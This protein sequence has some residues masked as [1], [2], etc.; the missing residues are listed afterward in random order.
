MEKHNV[1]FLIADESK[2]EQLLRNIDHLNKNKELIDKIAVVA[3]NTS[4]LSCLS[5]TM[6]NEF[7][8]KVKILSEQN[9]DFYLCDNT[10]KRYGI[11]SSNILP[12]FTIATEGGLAK[13]LLLEDV[14]YRLF[15]LG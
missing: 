6:L 14:N 12:Q 2:W 7:K 9:V 8:E 13:T 15:S 10:R 11:D 1:V 5:S 4:I 3:I